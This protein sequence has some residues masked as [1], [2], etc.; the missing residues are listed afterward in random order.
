MRR[1]LI[2]GATGFVGANLTRRLIVEGCEPH[3]LVRPQFQSWRLNG[4][5]DQVTLHEVGI[6]NRDAVRGLVSR[7]KPHW[8]FHLATYGAYPTQQGFERMVETNILDTAVIVDAALEAGVEA[9]VYTGSSSEYG[10]KDRPADEMDRVDPNSHY[11]ITKAT[12]THYC[13]W[14][15]R[16]HQLPV[17]NMRLYSIYGPF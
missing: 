13:Q 1:G 10:L 15:A 14:A 8:I 4:I 6:G 17:A 12:A 11:A 7:L 2:T 16:A 5:R 9:F 3:L